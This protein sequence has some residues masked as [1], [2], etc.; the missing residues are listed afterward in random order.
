MI[1]RKYHLHKYYDL[2]KIKIII[3]IPSLLKVWYIYWKIFHNLHNIYNPNFTLSSMKIILLF[4]TLAL[5]LKCIHTESLT[6]TYP[7][8]KQCD[9]T[10]ANDQLG[11]SSN[12]ICSAGCLMS[13]AA[14]ALTGTGRT[15]NP[16]TLNQWLRSNGGYVS[17]DLFVWASINK[18]GL[19]FKGFIANGNIKANR[20]WKCCHS[21]CPQRRALGFGNRIQWRQYPSKW[22][23]LSNNLLLPDPDSEWQHWSLWSVQYAIVCQ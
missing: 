6:R 10:W 3:Y 8:Y 1:T 16:R 12:T 2:K 18:F 19:T 21:Q 20:R 14:M 11:T 9:P 7:M 13:S 5:F 23:R 17:G 4:T 22:P 15:Q